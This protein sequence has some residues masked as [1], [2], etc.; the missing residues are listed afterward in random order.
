[1]GIAGFDGYGWPRMGVD[2]L[3]WVWRVLGGCGGPE[4]GEEG[5]RWVRRA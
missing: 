3:K 5:L 2:D 1:M 4:M